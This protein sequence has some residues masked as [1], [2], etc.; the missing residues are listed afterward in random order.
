LSARGPACGRGRLVAGLLAGS[1]LPGFGLGHPDLICSLFALVACFGE[2]FHHRLGPHD[3]GE[4]FFALLYLLGQAEA[5]RHRRFG[6][7]QH[8]L[9]LGFQLLGVLM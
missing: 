1:L 7:G 3:R 6:Q 2:R 5:I 9:E 4:T 8:L